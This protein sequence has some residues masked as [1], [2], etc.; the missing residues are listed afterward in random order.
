MS[1]DVEEFL[2]NALR[3]EGLKSF[4]IDSRINHYGQEEVSLRKKATGKK[5]GYDRSFDRA[6]MPDDIVAKELAQIAREFSEKIDDEIIT[7]YG[8]DTGMVEVKIH[9]GLSAQCR[10]CN[11]EVCVERGAVPSLA[12]GESS[13]P[14]PQPRDPESI[15]RRLS[16]IR[17]QL[18]DLYLIGKLRERCKPQCPNSMYSDREFDIDVDF[19]DDP[20]LASELARRDLTPEHLNIPSPFN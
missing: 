3:E 19:T 13:T 8:W 2:A 11:T 14:F 1:L 4:N 10:I 5:F 9:E 6:E 18:I 7:R 20:K 16:P 12:D 15:E 17:E